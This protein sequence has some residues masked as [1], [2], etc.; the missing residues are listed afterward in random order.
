MERSKDQ[1]SINYCLKAF[2]KKN[3]NRPSMKSDITVKMRTSTMESTNKLSSNKLSKA[4]SISFDE[5]LS[6]KPIQSKLNN[7][8]NVKL[9]SNMFLISFILSLVLYYALLFEDF[10]GVMEIP[11][12]ST[13]CAISQLRCFRKWKKNS[14]CFINHLTN[15]I[16]TLSHYSWTKASLTLNK[17]LIGKKSNIFKLSKAEKKKFNGKEMFSNSQK[18]SFGFLELVSEDCP[19]CCSCCGVSSFAC[20]ELENYRNKSLPFLDDLFFEVSQ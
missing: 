15:N 3:S 14:S 17:K 7:N 5:S 12:L 16:P 4:L 13:V 8:L 11:S 20:K 9:N 19:K 1:N 6:M 18:N 10:I 2:L